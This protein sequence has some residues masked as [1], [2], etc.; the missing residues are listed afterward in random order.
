M[1][2][3]LTIRDFIVENNMDY[4]AILVPSVGHSFKP[5]W[6]LSYFGHGANLGHPLLLVHML[7]SLGNT[8]V[9]QFVEMPSCLCMT[10]L[11]FLA[12]SM[13]TSGLLYS[14]IFLT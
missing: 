11:I 2:M 1:D 4:K 3:G 6:W 12:P 8:D 10:D 5:S 13:F 9:A 14:R 7:G